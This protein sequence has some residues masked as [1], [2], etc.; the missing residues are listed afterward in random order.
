MRRG[1]LTTRISRDAY[2]YGVS[3]PPAR[4]FIGRRAES[5]AFREFLLTDGPRVLLVTGRGGIGKTSLMD[6][7]VDIAS[8]TGRAV[9]S[10]EVTSSSI[11]TAIL[12]DLRRGFRDRTSAKA[13]GEF[14][15]AVRRLFQIENLAAGADHTKMSS[16]GWASRITQTVLFEAASVAI[17]RSVISG[18][19]IDEALGPAVEVAVGTLTNLATDQAE[20]FVGRLRRFGAADSDVRF[21]LDAD[22][23]LIELFAQATQESAQERGTIILIDAVDRNSRVASWLVD[24]LL[25]SLSGSRVHVCLAQRDWS[26]SPEWLSLPF[27]F[28]VQRLQPFTTEE[29]RDC[30]R[31]YRVPVELSDHV[32]AITEGVPLAVAL[33][34]EAYGLG[35]DSGA[36]DRASKDAVFGLTRSIV[37]RFDNPVLRQAVLA[38][39]VPRELTRDTLRTLIGSKADEVYLRLASFTSL[40]ESLPQGAMRLNDASRRSLR[41]YW[42]MSD[43]TGLSLLH[44]TL[45][46][47]FD[48]L[49]EST[50]LGPPI[51]RDLAKAVREAFYHH[52]HGGSPLAVVPSFRIADQLGAL[53]LCAGLLAE[54]REDPDLDEAV[55]PVIDW[56][57]GHW[58]ARR[59]E[60]TNANRSLR[61]ARRNRLATPAIL[62][63][64]QAEE[65]AMSEWRGDVNQ[66]IDGY[67]ASAAVFQLIG[68]TEDLGS[69][70]LRLG[71]V[72]AIRGSI[73]E[74]LRTFRRSYQLG[75]T[76][77]DKWL[78]RQSLFGAQLAYVYR[79]AW[80]QAR[81]C[82]RRALDQD[83]GPNQEGDATALVDHAIAEMLSGRTE[84]ARVSLQGVAS[85]AT[86]AGDRYLTALAEFNTAESYR[87][88]GDAKRAVDGI[89]AS[90]SAF[91]RLDAP[92]SL[93]VVQK[94]LA[95][96]LLAVERTDEAAFVLA[97]AR[98]TISAAKTQYELV[99]VMIAEGELALAEQDPAA[100]MRLFDSASGISAQ[101]PARH[102]ELSALEGLVRA[103]L[104]MG[105]WTRAEHLAKALLRRTRAHGYNDVSALLWQDLAISRAKR[106]QSH[107]SR[108][109]AARAVQS[110]KRHN[111]RYGDWIE[112]SVI[113]Q[114]A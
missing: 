4:Q 16:R 42:M 95:L 80:S 43:P 110:G 55:Q 39:A 63:M 76:I 3:H 45:A 103:A 96:A 70:L 37:D 23:V 12:V 85:Y 27:P 38:S 114:L 77:G 48:A 86:A 108:S 97:S 18:Y 61:R 75:N 2:T 26:P 13:F 29:L 72:L 84:E 98:T 1:N 17:S 11:P 8:A 64:V 9:Q 49:I 74:S 32:R 50:R 19:A 93:A 5:T 52:A 92:L 112:S 51:A 73:D 53:D 14:D 91:V 107:S 40:Y 58:H 68:R 62:A 47:S 57:A 106:G 25:P 35:A 87:L 31:E 69:V 94:S 89:Q 100:A 109:A 44:R 54:A 88:D 20:T 67:R 105:D 82:Y 71:K 36:L 30:L 113:Q 90:Q 60:W 78:A 34:A 104:A 111:V 22:Q 81:S 15:E 24:T 41:R 10:L 99:Q 59:Q 28:D 66:S 7:F 33:F 6:R 46:A 102:A 56:C 83:A 101:M 65:A 79:G 21:Y